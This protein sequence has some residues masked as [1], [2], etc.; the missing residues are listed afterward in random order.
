MSAWFVSGVKIV[1]CG[2]GAA[3]ALFVG[4]REGALLLFGA[5]GML[6]DLEVCEFVEGDGKEGEV[7]FPQHLPF[8]LVEEGEERHDH[9]LW[10]RTLL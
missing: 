3:L 10:I 4:R 6:C 7:P 9:F 2:G 8:G 1:A 5:L